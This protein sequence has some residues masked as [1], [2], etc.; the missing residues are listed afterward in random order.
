MLYPQVNIITYLLAIQT[1]NKVIYGIVTHFG[2]SNYICTS[3]SLVY[4][5]N[6]AIYDKDLQS[7]IASYDVE[8]VYRVYKETEG[9]TMTK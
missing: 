5:T 2:I 8:M 1:L 6:I 4:C 7:Y 3:P 9:T